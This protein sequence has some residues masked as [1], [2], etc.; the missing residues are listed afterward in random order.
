MNQVYVNRGRRALI[1]VAI[2]AYSLALITV[3]SLYAEA[4]TIV[5]LV[6][7]GLFS[8]VELVVMFYI[9]GSVIDSTNVGSVLASKVGLQSSYPPED[10]VEPS[11]GVSIEDVPPEAET[12]GPPKKRKKHT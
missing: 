3:L 12:M 5:E 11:G 10:S 8:L 1:S 7:K 4:T 2:I 6:V 9:G